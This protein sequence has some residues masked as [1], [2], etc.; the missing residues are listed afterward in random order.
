MKKFSIFLFYCLLWDG[1]RRNSVWYTQ[2]TT[3]G[4]LQ[5]DLRL[6]RSWPAVTTLWE[7]VNIPHT[8]NNKDADDET[9]GFI[10]DRLGTGNNCL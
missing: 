5:K 6:K 2:S 4:N 8:W 1:H 9:P 10:G 7:T 3:D